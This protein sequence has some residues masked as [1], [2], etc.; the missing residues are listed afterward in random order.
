MSKSGL[1]YGKE[2][3][4][5]MLALEAIFQADALVRLMMT[6]EDTEDMAEVIAGIGARLLQLFSVVITSLD[7]DMEGLEA[8][9]ERMYGTAKKGVRNV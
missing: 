3:P 4:R 2:T 1:D 8:I 5:V 7:D 6:A 9:S